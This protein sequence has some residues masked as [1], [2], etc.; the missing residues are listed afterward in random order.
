MLIRFHWGVGVGHVY[1]HTRSDL[2]DSQ[3]SADGAA[4]TTSPFLSDLS[5]QTQAQ[6]LDSN[7][8]EGS[9]DE[10]VDLNDVSDS[11]NSSEDDGGQDYEWDLN[12]NDTHGMYGEFDDDEAGYC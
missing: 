4:S 6:T 11:E 9:D 2:G 7:G 12:E 10:S 5:A 8:H 3:S 1:G